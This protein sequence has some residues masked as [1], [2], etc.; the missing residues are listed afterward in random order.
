MAGSEI[1]LDLE[2][3]TFGEMIAAEEASGKDITT[4]WSKAGSRMLLAVFIHRLRSSGVPPTWSELASLKVLDVSR[5]TSD[6]SPDGDST[7]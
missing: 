4:L 5:S 7:G 6:S 1:Q 2:A 3:L